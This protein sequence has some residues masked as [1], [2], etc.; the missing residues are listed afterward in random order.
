MNMLCVFKSY[1]ATKTL[2]FPLSL[3]FAGVDFTSCFFFTGDANETL[4]NDL[5][6]AIK[7]LSESIENKYINFCR[8]NFKQKLSRI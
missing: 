7:G 4:D 5:L 6:T 3:F 2:P 1:E 8:A